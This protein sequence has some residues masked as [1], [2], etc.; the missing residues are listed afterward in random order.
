MITFDVVREWALSFPEVTE[1]PH[2]EKTS[3]RIRKKIFAT[4]NS[5]KHLLTVKLSAEDQDV[6]SAADRSIIFPVDNRWGLQGWTSIDL[7]RVHPELLRDALTT[8]YCQ[9]APRK[10]A[11]K[12]RPLNEE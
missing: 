7:H 12:V 5:E 4:Y 9:V 10:L 11:E 6:F 1:E 8:A 3:F 2:F